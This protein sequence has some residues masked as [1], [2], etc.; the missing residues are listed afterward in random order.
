[1]YEQ[2]S[3]HSFSF[4]LCSENG[5]SNNFAENAIRPFVQGRK[6]WLFCDTPKGADS[7]AIVYSIV[8]TAKANGLD[9]LHIPE[10]PVDRAALSGKNPASDKLDLFMPWTAAIRKNCILPTK[11]FHPRTS[12][13]RPSGIF[14]LPDDY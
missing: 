4:S 3:K 5:I 12:D 8:E 6:A 9:P 14:L 2:H 10:T 1:L 7:S 13:A 11:R